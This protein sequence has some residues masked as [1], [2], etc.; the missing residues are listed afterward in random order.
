MLASGHPL[1]ARYFIEALKPVSDADEA[2]K[3]LSNTEGLGQSLQQIYERVWQKLDTARSSRAALGLLARAEGTLSSE[4]LANGSSDEA[5]EDVLATAGFLLSRN[6]SGR[7][8]IFHNS[9]RLFVA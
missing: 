7:L 2:E 3:I 1:T 4:Q 6:G 9:F 5:V 8:S